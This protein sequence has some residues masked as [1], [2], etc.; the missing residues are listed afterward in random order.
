MIVWAMSF[1]FVY[2]AALVSGWKPGFVA[3]IIGLALTVV[4][5]AAGAMHFVLE[6]RRQK[7]A[8]LSIESSLP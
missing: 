1:L 6:S 8:M 3:A 4:P 5:L 2:A 7:A